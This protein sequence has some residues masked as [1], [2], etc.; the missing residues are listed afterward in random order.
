MREEGKKLGVQFICCMGAGSVIMHNSGGE[1][2]CEAA[3]VLV[4]VFFVI[5]G[6]FAANKN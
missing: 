5:E 4:V 1:A 2:V 3:I 6:L